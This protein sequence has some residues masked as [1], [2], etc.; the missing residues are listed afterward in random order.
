MSEQRETSAEQG[1]RKNPWTR[2]YMWWL[3]ISF[4][5]LAVVLLI[6][7]I[8]NISY[9]VTTTPEVR[10][11]HAAATLEAQAAKDARK[12]HE[13]ATKEAR[14]AEE[15]AKAEAA[16]AFE[17]ATREAE[18]NSKRETGES[19]ETDRQATKEAEELEDS[20]MIM[21]ASGQLVPKYCVLLASNFVEIAGAF[22][23]IQDML[24]RAAAGEAQQGVVL[25]MLFEVQRLEVAAASIKELDRP[26]D[27]KDLDRSADK[28]ADEILDFHEKMVSGLVDDDAGDFKSGVLMIPRIE[29]AV[30][31]TWEVYK[32]SCGELTP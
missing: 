10:E 24:E 5:F 17:A 31:E 23:E 26:K 28:M 11:M 15:R 3:Y 14:D 19:E 20:D 29:A 27:M 12:A 22:P 1:S 13:D 16:E 8:A 18:E 2:W 21:T 6:V 30:L 9:A 25:Q 4:G 32:D 7:L